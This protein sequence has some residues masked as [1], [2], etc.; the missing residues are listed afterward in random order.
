MSTRIREGLARLDMPKEL[1]SREEIVGTASTPARP[2]FPPF[3]RDSAMQ[4][5]RLVE[6]A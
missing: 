3:T 5:V 6:D 1:I 4:K 2:L